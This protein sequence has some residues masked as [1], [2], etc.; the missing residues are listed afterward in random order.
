M[1]NAVMTW[2]QVAQ[3][4]STQ[5]AHACMRIPKWQVQHPRAAGMA[6]SLGLPVGQFGDWRMPYPNCHGLHV[7]EFTDHYTAHID[8]VNPNC[9]V[10]GHV[11]A[12]AP[13][14]GGG[15]ALGALIG[16]ILGES[17]GAMV[18][19]ALIG[20][21]L[22]ASATASTEAKACARPVKPRP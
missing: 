18:V 8:R 4:L 21:A 13:A 5:A 22:G 15:A 19:G 20:G 1:R 16:L 10:A 2:R 3:Q 12:D 11:N 17:A 7:R 9:D 14:V 6:R